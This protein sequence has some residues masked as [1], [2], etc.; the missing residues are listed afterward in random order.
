LVNI[1]AI[2][3]LTFYGGELVLAH[4]LLLLRAAAAAWVLALIEL[5]FAAPQEGALRLLGR[6]DPLWP[7][8]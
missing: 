6:R 7:L 1:G 5:G 8:W 4:P 2:D 3:L